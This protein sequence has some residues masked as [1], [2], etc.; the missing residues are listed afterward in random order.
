[1]FSFSS[2][3]HRPQLETLEDRIVPS[4]IPDGWIVETTSPSGFVPRDQWSSLAS[5]PTG[6]FAVDPSTGNQALVAARSG[7]LLSLPE[8]ITI[9]DGRLYVADHHVF[10]PGGG[11]ILQVDPAD[12]SESL[13]APPGDLHHIH[14]PTALTYID[15]SLYVASSGN[16]AGTVL[17]NL[18][19]VNLQ[20]LAQT[21][22]SYGGNFVDPVGLAPVPGNDN[23]VYLADAKAGSSGTGAIFEVDLSTGA[24][25]EITEGNLLNFPA[26]I[27]QELDPD[28]G[29]PTGNLLVI[30]GG[31]GN[32][33]RVSPDGM[34]TLLTSFGSGSGVRSI[35]AGSGI[36]GPGTIFVGA[37]ASGTA[38]AILFAA[39]PR[40]GA[41]T[42][43]SSGGNLSLVAGLAFSSDA[44]QLYV[45]TSPSPS[46]TPI[47]TSAPTGIIGVD[48]MTG[49]QTAVSVRPAGLFGLP[50]EI[51]E[52]PAP[53]DNLYVA[54]LTAF[55]TGAVVRIDP[56]DGS[57]T[58]LATGGYLDAPNSITFLN[59]YIYVADTGDSSGFTHNIVRIDPNNLDITSNQTLITDGSGWADFFTNPTGIA[60]VVGDPDS[61]YVGDEPG[62]VGGNLPGQIWKVN[63][64]T[65][66]QSRFGPMF[67]TS[68]FEAHLDRIAV[69]P[70]TGNLYASTIG[71]DG[72][73]GSLVLVGP[74]SLTEL[75]AHDKLIGDNG[76]AVSLDGSVIY[77]PTIA[78]GAVPAARILAID[79]TDPNGAQSIVT[80]GSNLSLVAGLRVFQANGGNGSPPPSPSPAALLIRPTQLPPLPVPLMQPAVHR[81]DT[82]MA[83]R[84]TT[85]QQAVD[86][87]FAEWAMLDNRIPMHPRA[88]APARADISGLDESDSPLLARDAILIR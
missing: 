1:M 62:N 52:G 19:Q 80:E 76:I 44:N 78:S 85:P 27:T 61:I 48:P 53:Q 3:A 68:G 87:L 58:L 4:L 60:P 79:L 84:P 6:V 88:T 46:S 57:Q 51:C 72:T 18:V 40:T 14:G 5:F 43:L 41:Q 50:L 70:R 65:G 2:R 59:G 31:D 81:Q 86:S 77:I 16:D 15:G 38:P 49:V 28:S 10:G 7:G 69:D 22:I 34:Q 63:I 35:V 67:P 54:D 8:A 64:Q 20:S 13:I 37:M 25:N 83:L 75:S 45:G 74:D 11:G 24:Q 17:P 9:V 73:A 21:E 56:S 42:V 47:D 82:T 23:E 55:D 66:A 39:D 33:V 71:G 29:L 12:G 26:G 30:N 36:D 32:A